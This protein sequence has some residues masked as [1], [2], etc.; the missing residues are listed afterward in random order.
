MLD[1]G[2]GRK[3]LVLDLREAPWRRRLSDNM[4]GA[5]PMSYCGRRTVALAARSVTDKHEVA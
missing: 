4:A 1:R 2:P 3:Q 5:A